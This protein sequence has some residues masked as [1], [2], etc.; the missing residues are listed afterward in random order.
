MLVL[1]RCVAE[2]IVARG[3]RGLA[4]FVPGGPYLYDIAADAHKRLKDRRQHDQ[5]RSDIQ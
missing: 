4:E 2:A 5:F 1:M 3:V